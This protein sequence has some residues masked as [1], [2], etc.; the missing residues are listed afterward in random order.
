MPAAAVIGGIG[1]AA[2][3][4]TA[5]AAA[6]TTLGAIAAGVTIAG[7]VATALGGI[8]GNKTLMKIGAVAGIAG[9]AGSLATR[10]TGGAGTAAGAAAD[11]ST[12]LWS[13]GAKAVGGS[14]ASAG[15]LAGGL[16]SAAQL[17]VP[18][19]MRVPDVGSTSG[20]LLSSSSESLGAPKRFTGVSDA[21]PAS[22]AEQVPAGANADIPTSEIGRSMTDATREGRKSLVMPK[23]G[24]LLSSAG[25][26]ME[27]NPELT[28]IGG[29]M[30]SGYSQG[31][32]EE[33]K[34]REEERRM[35]EARRRYQDSI[36]G[37]RDRW[38]TQQQ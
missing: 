29:Q 37:Q 25:N 38:A 2:A 34:L 21:N 33:K 31:S 30:L 11:G 36:S 4:A 20:G 23:L 10:L 6:T 7:G 5:F 3:G 17:N 35:E 16:P 24:G 12:S 18:S 19:G 14:G 32:M 13:G 28:K 15:G 1:A 27:K 9:G 26:F 8:T 22:V